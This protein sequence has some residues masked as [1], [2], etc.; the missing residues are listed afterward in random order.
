M[1]ITYD[2]SGKG[3]FEE[4]RHVRI[5]FF[6]GTG[7]T[8]RIAAAFENEL[9]GRGLDVSVINLG[10][11][12]QEEMDQSRQEKIDQSRQGKKDWQEEQ[13]RDRAEGR[14]EDRAEGRADLNILIYPVYAMDAPKPV[15]DWI[16][17]LDSSVPAG[18]IA[19]ISVSGGGEMWPNKGCRNGCCKALESKGFQVIYDCMMCMPANVLVSYSDDLA[20]H[21]IRVIP[22]K[23][24]RITG[25]LLKGK[26]HR[27]RFRKGIVLNWI[28][29]TER[30][31]AG[32]FAQRFLISND[33]TSC[34]WCVR[35]CPVSNIEI[36][37][38]ASKPHFL[39]RCVICT[40]CV[41]GCPAHAIKTKSSVTLKTGFD[42]DA[43]EQRMKDV[44]LQPFE[45][46]C[47]GWLYKGVK[48][49]LLDRY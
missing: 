39:D 35:N 15:S 45:K 46:F 13:Y 19:V 43:V 29:R 34:G 21:L 9:K 18:K 6:S 17:S 14:A 36:T 31:N 42:L 4:T 27:T 22:E 20:M 8:K 10:K 23:V 11:S 40:R 49:Y 24:S 1:M 32:K 38:G 5:I 47:K 41:Y 33:C 37:K 12:R 30:E 3:I 44:E 25:E 48:D 2:E 26:I 7:G 16:E 28:S